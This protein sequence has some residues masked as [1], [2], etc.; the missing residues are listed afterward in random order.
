[1]RTNYL[2]VER[3]VDEKIHGF[4]MNDYLWTEEFSS[5]SDVMKNLKKFNYIHRTGIGLIRIGSDSF[6]VFQIKE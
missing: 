6:H 5:F 2:G 3:I 4:P 1:M